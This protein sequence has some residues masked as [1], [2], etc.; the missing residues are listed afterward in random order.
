[1]SWLKKIFSSQSSQET[2]VY[3]E[4]EKDKKE[5]EKQQVTKS[6]ME[7]LQIDDS[8]SSWWSLWS[9]LSQKFS[10]SLKGEKRNW[11]ELSCD[12]E[13]NW[14]DSFKS[15]QKSTHK[16]PKKVVPP[17]KKVI[18]MKITINKEKK[19][20]MKMMMTILK[21]NFMLNVAEI[22]NLNI[23]DLFLFLVT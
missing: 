20:E 22:I 21:L 6:K 7:N 11:G 8:Q 16:A 9:G 10:N 1:M 18:K 2:K 13:E 14:W 3:Y 4:I 19:E 15:S 12:E 23:T 17:K 5:E